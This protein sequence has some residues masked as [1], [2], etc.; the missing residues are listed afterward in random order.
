M[1]IDGI[2]NLT[3]GTTETEE[4]QTIGKTA[5]EQEADAAARKAELIA[6]NDEHN[7]RVGGGYTNNQ[8]AD[9]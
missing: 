4:K 9:S 1:G 3:D 2:E 7:R 5:A 6:D 8:N